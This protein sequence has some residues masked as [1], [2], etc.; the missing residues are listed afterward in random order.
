MTIV[1]EGEH[2][3]FL[4]SPAQLINDDREV[5]DGWASK[6]I[7]ANPSLKWVVGKY[8]EADNA[9]SNGQYWT[10]DDLRISQPTINHT[11]LN[12]GHVANNIIGTIVAS[13]MMF[14]IEGASV[15][16]P[17]IEVAAAIW[18]W[19]FPDEMTKIESAWEAGELFISMECVA[20]TVTCSGDEGCGQTFEYVGPMSEDYCSHIQERSSIRQLNKPT[21]LAGGMIIP[22]I[23]P[24]WK[25]ARMDMVA[26][27]LNDEKIDQ[28]IEAVAKESPDASPQSWE[29]TMWALQQQALVESSASTQ[30]KKEL[31]S[32]SLIGYHIARQFLA[33]SFK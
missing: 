7:V 6:H 31:T 9:N 25:N 12:V 15:D 5:A 22:P 32:P 27:G 18:K 11:P 17:Y 13:E 19:Y 21:F 23:K 1:T 29:A 8:V 14:P 16:N 10:Y 24:G 20:E 28:M 4:N 3:F 2:S 33:S 26:A 30:V